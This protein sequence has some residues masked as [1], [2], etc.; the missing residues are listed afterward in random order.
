MKESYL[1][2]E[3]LKWLLG[4]GLKSLKDLT[5]AAMVSTRDDALETKA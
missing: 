1:S 4:L 5:S 2:I 3:T